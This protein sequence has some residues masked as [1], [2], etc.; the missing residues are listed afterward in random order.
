MKIECQNCGS[1]YN[2]PDERLKN[3]GE[4]I[5]LPCPK[6]KNKIVVKSPERPNNIKCKKC[7]AKG[8]LKGD[9][10][11]PKDKDK[12]AKKKPKEEE[13]EPEKGK[14]KE[15]EPKKEKKKGKG[16]SKDE[17]AEETI[18]GPSEPGEDEEVFHEPRKGIWQPSDKEL[19]FDDAPEVEK[20]PK[21]E[22]EEVEKKPKKKKG[23][24]KEKAK[25]REPEEEPKPKKEKAKDK[26]REKPGKEKP[27]KK[28]KPLK[29]KCKC[30]GEIV[31]KSSKRPIKIECPK[32]GKTGML[33]K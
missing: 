29:I 25:E 21:E 13:T 6:C 23:K 12:E 33:R 16:R 32:C 24:V 17:D 4:L 22:E 10:K 11:K 15:K 20:K 2:V 1:V 28:G 26:D 19:K 5:I 7:G 9:K 3:Y 27:L 31:V 30:G 18:T 8:T 14:E